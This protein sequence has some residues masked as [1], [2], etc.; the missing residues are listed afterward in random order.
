MTNDADQKVSCS[1]FSFYNTT[2]EQCNFLISTDCLE[3]DALID[4]VGYIFCTA[5]IE[6]REIAVLSTSLLL[7]LL[8]LALGIVADDFLCP[9]LLALARSMRMSDCLAVSRQFRLPCLHFLSKNI[10]K[11]VL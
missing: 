5:G 6:Y 4:Y 3:S 7:I 9:N 1:N 11:L 8:F 10:I 2:E